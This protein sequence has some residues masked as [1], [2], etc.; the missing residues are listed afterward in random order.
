MYKCPYCKHTLITKNLKQG[1]YGRCSY[2][3]FSGYIPKIGLEEVKTEL[4]KVKTGSD[5]GVQLSDEEIRGIKEWLNKIRKKY[6]I[7][8]PIPEKI[9]AEEL[10]KEKKK[11]KKEGLDT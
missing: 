8:G 5:K 6:K 11:L 4:E 2:C 3:R 7:K 10:E 1:L 9:V